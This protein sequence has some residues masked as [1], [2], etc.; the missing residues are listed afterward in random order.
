MSLNQELMKQINQISGKENKENNYTS[1]AKSAL[2]DDE[3]QIDF[4]MN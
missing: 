3:E 4:L 1:P 2:V